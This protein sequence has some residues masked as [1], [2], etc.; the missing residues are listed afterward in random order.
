MPVDMELDKDSWKLR[1]VNGDL[2]LIGKKTGVSD[3]RIDELV[4][5]LKIKLSFFRSEWF[6]DEDAG[7]PYYT[8]ILVKNPNI[9]NIDNIFKVAI[10]EA[11]GVN[12]ILDF[13]SEYDT[14]ARSYTMSFRVNTIY[15]D[16]G[17]I[18]V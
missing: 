3:T 18:N 13:S 7:I 11:E 9:S 10:S 6:L 1:I 12:Q 5:H 14:L 8:D 2:V 16:T 17:V 15:G 4:Q